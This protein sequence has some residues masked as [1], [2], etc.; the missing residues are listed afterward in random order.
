MRFSENEAMLIAMATMRAQPSHAD[1]LKAVLERLAAAS[2]GE[3][4][5][6]AY[7]VFRSTQDATVFTTFEQWATPA[8]EAQHMICEHVAEAFKAA[9]PLLA[10]PPEIR[11]FEEF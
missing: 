6:A 8:A 11:H 9:G 2:R 1:A 3:A 10:A 4:G 5:C 7:R